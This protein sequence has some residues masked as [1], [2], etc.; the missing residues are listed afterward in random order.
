MS[1][2]NNEVAAMRTL[3]DWAASLC[4]TEVDAAM[5]D[6]LCSEQSRAL[7]L[8]VEPSLQT[9]LDLPHEKAIEEGQEAYAA[10]FLLPA[11][12]GLRLAGYAEGDSERVGPIMADE[13]S[14]LLGV[15]NLGPD[16]K[17]FGK[18]PIDHA[19]ISLSA[20]AALVAADPMPKVT[21]LE[22]AEFM[23][24]LERWAKSL[25]AH[26]KAHPLYRA[27]GKL[28]CELIEAT[29]QL[30][31]AASGEGPELRLPVLA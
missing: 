9:W 30:F 29:N 21:D 8:E 17:R 14:K 19:A 1:Q 5:R 15:L 6:R 26:P 22:K 23:Q 20:L 12:P 7:L 2:T 13:L 3:L 11:G 4:L 25:S 31:A 16:D 24:A 27:V 10:T 18:L 28:C